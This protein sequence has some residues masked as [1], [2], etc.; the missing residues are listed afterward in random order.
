M[1]FETEAISISST[2]TGVVEVYAKWRYD[3]DN[4]SRSGKYTINNSSPTSQTY[5]DSK[6]LNLTQELAD[7]LAKIGITKLTF[8]LQLRH[9][10]EGTA[11]IYI[12]NDDVKLWSDT[13]T[14]GTSSSKP[15]V[16]STQI[17]LDIVD[18]LVEDPENDGEYMYS[19]YLYIRY[20]ASS[21]TYLIF[22]TKSHYWY[23]DLIYME[24]SY[25]VNEEDLNDPNH[26]FAW[27]Y[28]NPFNEE[29]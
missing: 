21:Y 19:N 15:K 26:V 29:S 17:T 16:Y 25:V 2:Q 8:N 9:W 11:S 3:V 24:M 13:F 28:Q 23:N 7:E 20:K 1:T 6:F 10:G 4:P 5:E 18:L 22:W 14:P 12:Y 27:A